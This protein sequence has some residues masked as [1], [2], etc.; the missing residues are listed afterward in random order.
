MGEGRCYTQGGQGGLPLKRDRF[1][2]ELREQAMWVS[3]G[4][5]FQGKE[6]AGG[7][8]LQCARAWCIRETA[9]WPVCV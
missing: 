9:R 3:G 1:L 7:K 5:D 6:I 2:W 4:R 8:V